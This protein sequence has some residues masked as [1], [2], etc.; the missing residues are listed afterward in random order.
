MDTSH[1]CGIVMMDTIVRGGFSIFFPFHSLV[2]CLILEQLF[3]G[4]FTAYVSFT[5]KGG[6]LMEQQG[7]LV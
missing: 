2:T 6:V 4:Q 3:T 5:T 7:L 1:S